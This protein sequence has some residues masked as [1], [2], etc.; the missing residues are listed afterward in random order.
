MKQKYTLEDLEKLQ[1]RI[2]RAKA[3]DDLFEKI[4]SK[5]AAQKPDNIMLLRIAAGLTILIALN[6]WAWASFN[7]N[8]AEENSWQYSSAGY[9][10]SY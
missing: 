9:S 6:L 10:I 1:S 3:P 2:G 8:S 7:N 4:Q 5:R